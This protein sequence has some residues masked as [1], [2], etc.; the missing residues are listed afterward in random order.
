VNVSTRGQAIVTVALALSLWWVVATR[1]PAHACGHCIEDKVAATYDYAVLTCA[2]RNGHVVVFAD[3]RG[4]AAGA[5]PA[6]KAFIIHTLASTSGI[7][8]GTVRVS[9]DPPAA[10]FACDPVRHAPSALLDTVNPQLAAK[11]LRLAVIKID[12]GPRSK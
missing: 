4:P 11:G 8:G 5:G 10:S 3:L 2:A 7:D 6:L 1:T 12:H 9:L